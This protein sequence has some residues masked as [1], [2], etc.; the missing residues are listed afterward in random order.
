MISLSVSVSWAL[1]DGAILRVLE[2]RTP[3]PLPA[4]AQPRFLAEEL[5]THRTRAYNEMHPELQTIDSSKPGCACRQLS[6]CT[7]HWSHYWTASPTSTH[8]PTP[9]SHRPVCIMMSHPSP[10]P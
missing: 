5:V 1:A 3:P 6:R 8:L 10:G 9:S 2:E 4:D 7:S